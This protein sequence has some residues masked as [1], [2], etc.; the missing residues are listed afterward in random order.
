MILYPE[1]FKGIDRYCKNIIFKSILFKKIIRLKS[2]SA[3]RFVI[4]I[5]KCVCVL[6]SSSAFVLD[7]LAHFSKSFVVFKQKPKTG[8]NSM[9]IDRFCALTSNCVMQSISSYTGFS[10]LQKQIV[11]SICI[12]RFSSTNRN[13]TKIALR[14][15]N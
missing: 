7:W 11:F 4:I 2:M 5:W 3:D 10:I 15:L 1:I 6:L 14:K 9:S 12:L 8:K 13:F